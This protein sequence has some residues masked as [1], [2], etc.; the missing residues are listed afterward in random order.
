MQSYKNNELI[1]TQTGPLEKLTEE[2]KKDKKSTHHVIGKI[3]KTGS[4]IIV[5]GLIYKVI[6][7]NPLKGMLVAK[8]K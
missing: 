7:S 6:S 4:E 1:K 5:N 3:P 2:M 8:I